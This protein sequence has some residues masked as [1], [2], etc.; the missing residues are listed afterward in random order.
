VV[1]AVVVLI[2]LPDDIPVEAEIVAD[3]AN[4]EAGIGLALPI[5]Y[6]ATAVDMGP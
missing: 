5:G 6:G 3:D 2:V 1:V 4:S